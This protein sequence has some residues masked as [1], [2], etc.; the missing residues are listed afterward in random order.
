MYTL[1]SPLS[2]HSS[3]ELPGWVFCWRP[4]SI[5]PSSSPPPQ[6]LATVLRLGRESATP[7][8]SFIQGGFFSIFVYIYTR[9]VYI[10]IYT[11]IQNLDYRLSF[12][13]ILPRKKE[14]ERERERDR[15]AL[16]S[17]NKQ[18]HFLFFFTIAFASPSRGGGTSRVNG[19]VTTPGY[20]QKQ[21]SEQDEDEPPRIAG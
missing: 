3:T 14:R 11:Y 13:I 19:Q 4:L 8:R 21:N 2:P 16:V 1:V 15:E 7:R 18:Q 5:W 12:D 6:F 17:V 20:S 9:G 10:Y